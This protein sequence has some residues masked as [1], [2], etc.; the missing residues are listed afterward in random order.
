MENMS[1]LAVIEEHDFGGLTVKTYSNGEAIFEFDDDATAALN[2][3]AAM[4]HITFEEA[5]EESIR[6]IDENKDRF[7]ETIQQYSA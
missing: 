3:I 2:Y 7:P 4:R 1:E 6:F 5:F